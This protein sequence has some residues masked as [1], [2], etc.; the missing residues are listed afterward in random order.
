MSERISCAKAPCKSCPYRRDV[1]SGV[2]AAEEYDKLPGYDG[3]MASQLLSGS[4]GL[5]Y[6]H[7]QDGRLCA[8]WVGTHGPHNL[9]ALRLTSC[10]GHDQ[11]DSSVWAYKSPVPLFKSGAAACAHGKRAIRRPGPKARRTAERLVR[12]LGLEE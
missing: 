7:Q 2:W 6:C 1:P 5:F 9:I 10:S 12:K 3:D 8:G 4:G 11:I